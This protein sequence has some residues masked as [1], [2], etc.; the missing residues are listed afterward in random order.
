MKKSLII[1]GLA[2]SVMLSSSMANADTATKAVN[3]NPAPQSAECPKDFKGQKPPKRMTPPNIDERLKLT[4]EQ[5]KQAHEIRMKGHEQIKPIFDKIKAKKEEIRKIVDNQK[6]T[7]DKKD[8][9]I[10]ALEIEI[11][12]LKQQARKLQ[13]QN[14]KEFESILTA[15]QKAEFEK[16]KEEGRKMHEMKR[17]HFPP[18]RPDF[19]PERR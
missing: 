11:L 4:E 1:A 3:T 19:G 16:I 12:K 13:M 18:Q 9:A 6:L 15:V 8:K 14:T 5:K 7:Q 17:P 10:D 2:A